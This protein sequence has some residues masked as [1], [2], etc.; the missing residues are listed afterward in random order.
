M[1]SPNS[2]HPIGQLADD[3]QMVLGAIERRSFRIYKTLAVEP[4]ED[5]CRIRGALRK[6]QHLDHE[7][8]ERRVNPPPI[9][10]RIPIGPLAGI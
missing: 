2:L 4:L 9:P 8:N 6:D 10:I 7:Q 1:T 5:R 3:P